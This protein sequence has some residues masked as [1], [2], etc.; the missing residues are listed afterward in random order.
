MAGTVNNYKTSILASSPALSNAHRKETPDIPKT[1]DR[2]HDQ[3]RY[4]NRKSC[5]NLG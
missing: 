4:K 2:D 1:F 5:L 3:P